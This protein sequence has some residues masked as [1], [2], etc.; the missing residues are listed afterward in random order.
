MSGEDGDGDGDGKGGDGGAGFLAAVVFDAEGLVP[1]IAQDRQTGV[2]RMFA[3]ANAA[4]LRAT[5]ES[6][7]ATFWSRSRGRLWCKGEE[8][9]NVLGVRE[10][11]LDCDGDAV[12]YLCDAVGPSCH[13][14]QTSCFYRVGSPPVE[15]GGPGEA[16]AAILS[17]LAEVIAERR[18]Q[19]ADK[20]YVASL[21][22]KGLPKINAKITEEAREVTEALLEGDAGHIAHEAADV[23]FHL[24]VGL[25]AANVPIDDVLA[26]LR[27]RFGVSG[28]L[29]KQSRAAPAKPSD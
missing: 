25:E 7:R 12:L 19:N 6:G 28:H 4:A 22:S 17:R 11:R 3:F 13:T 29:E 23:L 20:S 24:M 16:P 1:V 2:V 26:E 14:G 21:L 15:D 5:F 18:Q 10:I 8:S 27:R 9:G